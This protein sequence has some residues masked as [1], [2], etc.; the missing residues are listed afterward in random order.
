MEGRA[1]RSV[2]A[3]RTGAGRRGGPLGSGTPP[4]GPGLVL[5]GPPGDRGRGPVQRGGG[6]FGGGPI[7]LRPWMMSYNLVLL[8]LH[9]VALGAALAGAWLIAPAGVGR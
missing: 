9:L 3:C 8:S 1:G 6:G 7:R 5:P 4:A 2:H